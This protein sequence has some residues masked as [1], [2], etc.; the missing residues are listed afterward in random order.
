MSE[1]E[2]WDGSAEQ[3]GRPHDTEQMEMVEAW[4]R[5]PHCSHDE[6]HVDHPGRLV[7]CCCGVVSGDPKWLD[8]CPHPK[9]GVIP[10]DDEGGDEFEFD[11]QDW[12]YVVDAMRHVLGLEDR[13]KCFACY[14]DTEG[15]GWQDCPEHGSQQVVGSGTTGGPDPWGTDQLACGHEVLD[16]LSERDKMALGCP[17]RKPDIVRVWS[18]SRLRDAVVVAA[19]NEAA[20]R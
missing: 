13:R 1:L 4:G 3:V 19:F 6:G 14:T 18:K 8:D 11:G 12:W 20:G 7:C 10:L 15:M 2:R 9:G 17:D 5:A 16:M